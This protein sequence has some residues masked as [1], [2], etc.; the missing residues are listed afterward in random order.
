M[1]DAGARKRG[2][3]WNRGSCQG[4]DTWCGT[5][6]T[7]RF[8]VA[9]QVADVEDPH[10]EDN[11]QLADDGGACEHLAKGVLPQAECHG[12]RVATEDAPSQLEESAR[13]IGQHRVLGC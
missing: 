11:E 12:E 4:Q 3:L 6:R 7:C 1:M 9:A 8:Y 13:P 2:H 5:G 10:A